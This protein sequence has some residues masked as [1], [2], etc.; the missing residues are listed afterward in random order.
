MDLV[1]SVTHIPVYAFQSYEK[2]LWYLLPNLVWLFAAFLS[3]WLI[4]WKY[5]IP[6]IVFAGLIIA[7][8][9]VIMT[10][11]LQA[12]KVAYK[13]PSG[14]WVEIGIHVGTVLTAM[15][16]GPVVTNIF[17]LS[18]EQ[19]PEASAAQISSLAS[20]FVFS[21]TLGSWLNSLI[22]GS[23][24]Y[25][26]SSSK[27]L[28]KPLLDLCH[29]CTLMAATTIIAFAKSKFLDNSPTSQNTKIIFQV[30]KYAYQHNKPQHRSALTYWEDEPPNRLN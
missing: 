12:A 20:W 7:G 23:F 1:A 14:K 26:M 27:Y 24:K 2:H 13:S 11:I 3:A 15:G 8:M 5:K 10:T 30:L 25:C 17:Q 28:H 29:A 9:G 4:G 19:I 16:G 22:I 18:L 21:Y 6:D